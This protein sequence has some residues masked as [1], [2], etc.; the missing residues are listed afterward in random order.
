MKLS[1]GELM[2]ILN[3]LSKENRIKLFAYISVLQEKTIKSFLD[4]FFTPWGVATL[5]ITVLFFIVIYGMRLDLLSSKEV[6]AICQIIAGVTGASA[7]VGGIVVLG[8]RHLK[9]R[10]LVS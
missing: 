6:V 3:E 10:G 8:F 1:A 2:R 7:G 5:I 4:N 9:N